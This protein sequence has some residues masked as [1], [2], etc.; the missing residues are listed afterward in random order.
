[1]PNE[2]KITAAFV[3]QYHDAY[4]LATR[5]RESRLLTTVQNR[6]KIEDF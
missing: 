6:G 5:Q 1:M 2:F 3:Q 4:E